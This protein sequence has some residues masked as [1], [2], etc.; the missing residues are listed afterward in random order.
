MENLTT[1]P[2]TNLIN[3]YFQKGQ[4][5]QVTVDNIRGT[6]PDFS[7]DSDIQK[8]QNLHHRCFTGS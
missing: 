1:M 5:Y 4:E 7:M 6:D 8:A 3:K 2:T